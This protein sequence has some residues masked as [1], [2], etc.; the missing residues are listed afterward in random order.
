[1][2]NEEKDIELI[3][4]YF[5]LALSE[6]ELSVF[7]KRMNEDSQ[8]L[9][10]IELYGEG[11]AFINK[12]YQTEEE[13]SRTRKWNDL[14]FSD[15]KT[16]G[17][18]IPWRWIGGIAA[19]F[20]VL[21]FGW[22]YTSTVSEP[23]HEYASKEAW[24]KQIGLDYSQMR[25]ESGNSLK[26]NI[27]IAYYKYTKQ[28]YEEVIDMLGH[29]DSSVLY[30]EDALLLQGLSYYKSRDTIKALKK[31]KILSDYPTQ[32]KAKVARWYMGLIYLDK[33]N[34]KKAKQFLKLPTSKDSEIRLKE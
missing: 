8:F 13:T 18:V 27:H 23:D 7:E 16:K 20:A 21:F 29:F 24:N 34:I 12:E 5:D 22:Q 33:K 26:T 25:G 15:Y 1:M 14:M 2:A 30:Y 31:L 4:R 6:S 32:K 3:A 19:V 11:N 17:K 28:E 10:K 9:T